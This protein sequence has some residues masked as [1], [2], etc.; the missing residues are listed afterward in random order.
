MKKTIRIA[1][2][3]LLCTV[4]SVAG[5]S[6]EKKELSKKLPPIKMLPKIGEK[7]EIYELPQ[8]FEY[9][10]FDTMGR[11]VAEGDAEFIDIT[12]YKTGTYFIHYNKKTVKIEKS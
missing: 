2:I 1:S 5:Y 8:K 3:F 11:L 7:K 10:I 12:N 4:I 6:Q 9:K